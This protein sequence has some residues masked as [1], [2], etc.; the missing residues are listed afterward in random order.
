MSPLLGNITVEG[1][2]VNLPE[3]VMTPERVT[4]DGKGGVTESTFAR[5]IASQHLETEARL[6]KE[7]VEQ[8]LWGHPLVTEYMEMCVAARVLRRMRNY[9]E[10]VDSL[11]ADANI[12]LNLFLSGFANIAEDIGP[13]AAV[14]FEDTPGQSEWLPNSK[15][16]YDGFLGMTDDAR[17]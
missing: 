13:V 8:T 4:V 3:N 17:Q 15:Y 10:I 6:R 12:K 5:F 2:W 7:G 9:Q 14:E 16:V 1:V 11:F